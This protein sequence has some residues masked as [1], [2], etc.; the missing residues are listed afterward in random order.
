M[1]NEQPA[2]DPGQSVQPGAVFPAL[3]GSV[4][5]LTASRLSRP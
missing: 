5:R 2:T 4:T 3:G 1:V